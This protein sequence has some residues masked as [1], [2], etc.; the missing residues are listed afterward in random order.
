[1]TDSEAMILRQYSIDAGLCTAPDS[2]DSTPAAWSAYVGAEPEKP[3]NCITFYD[4]E[5]LDDRRV[6]VTGN[7][8]GPNGVQIRVRAINYPTGWTKINAI[9]DQYML[10]SSSFAYPYQRAVTVNARNYVIECVVGIGP[11]LSLGKQLPNSR[12][13]LFTFNVLVRAR[14]A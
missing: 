8:V 13:N 6:M 11:V 4:T 7:V 14:E 1:M 12:L 2:T 5:G 3:D 9:R 10:A